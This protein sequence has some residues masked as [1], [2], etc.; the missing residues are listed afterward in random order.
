MNAA[1][2]RKKRGGSTLLQRTKRDPERAAHIDKLV[3]VAAVEQIVQAIMEQQDISAAELAR[4]LNAKPPQI[5]RDLHGGLSKA[6][7]SRLC[8]IAEAL[9]YDFFPALVPRANTAKRERFMKAYRALVPDSA[10]GFV[11]EARNV[12]VPV[13]RR[14]KIA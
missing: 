11:T 3:R 8:T 14:R 7:M 2:A 10:Q 6:T 4:R 13:K 5:S 1:E 9:G 12:P